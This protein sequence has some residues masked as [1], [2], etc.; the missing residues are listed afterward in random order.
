[1][2]VTTKSAIATAGLSGHAK[3]RGPA[4]S[5]VGGPAESRLEATT[6]TRNG[7]D[8]DHASSLRPITRFAAVPADHRLG[9]YLPSQDSRY[10]RFV[11]AVQ[12]LRI[13]RDGTTLSAAQLARIMEAAEEIFMIGDGIPHEVRPAKA[14]AEAEAEAEPQTRAESPASQVRATEPAVAGEDAAEP[15]DGLA[16]VPGA[17]TEDAEPAL[18]EPVITGT[19]GAEG[20]D[21]PD[22]PDGSTAAMPLRTGMP[23]ADD[24][25]IDGPDLTAEP[26]PVRTPAHGAPPE[27]E[28]A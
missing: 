1:M 23:P 26:G 15:A 14:E 4:R 12:A 13:D 22:L 20:A 16:P 24:T 18:P 21:A 8:G 27:V 25:S 9:G 10:V 6:G 11:D 28:S 7:H 17:A 19:V 2:S 5:A 3:P